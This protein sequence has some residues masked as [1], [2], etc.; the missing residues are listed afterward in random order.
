MKTSNRRKILFVPP[1]FI[2]ALLSRGLVRNQFFCI[3]EPLGLPET[4][5]VAGVHTDYE[6]GSIA[7]VIEDESFEEVVAG[8]AYPRLEVQWGTHEVL[9]KPLSAEAFFAESDL[10]LVHVQDV[11]NP[12]RKA[13]GLDTVS[14][15]AARQLFA[16]V[17][18]GEY[19]K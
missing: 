2:A 16:S 3:P 19:R 14:D 1:N 15:G 12:A 4:A 6:R 13:E 9:L 11:I 8:M 17:M 5:R 10:F 7:L 18:R